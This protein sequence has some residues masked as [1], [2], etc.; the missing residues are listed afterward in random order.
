M[1]SSYPSE[2]GSTDDF[3]SRQAAWEIT[4]KAAAIRVM[5][6]VYLKELYPGGSLADEFA[7]V[8]NLDP[9]AVRPRFSELCVQGVIEK[10]R[11]TRRASRSHKRAAV[12]KWLPPRRE[13]I[14]ESLL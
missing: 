4:P 5:V 9:L 13:P 2:P 14:Q 8:S 3:T 10:T 6:E 7:R 11:E 12:Y 1:V